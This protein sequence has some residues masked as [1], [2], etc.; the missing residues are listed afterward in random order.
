MGTGNRVDQIFRC[1]GPTSASERW[2][3]P[4][5][6]IGGTMSGVPWPRPKRRLWARSCFFEL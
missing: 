5:P 6:L 2:S 3:A 4:R 1:L